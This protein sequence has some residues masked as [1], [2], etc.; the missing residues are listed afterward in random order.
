MELENDFEPEGM[1][2][3]DAVCGAGWNDE[4]RFEGDDCPLDGD[5][6]SALASIG[7]GTDEDYFHGD[8]GGDE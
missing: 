4:N 1:I 8:M 2:A 7:W 6:E 5:A 3:E